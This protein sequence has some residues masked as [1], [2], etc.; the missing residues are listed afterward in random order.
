MSSRILSK[1]KNIP[2]TNSFDLWKLISNLQNLKCSYFLVYSQFV[3]V[4]CV[5]VHT[6]MCGML[7]IAVLA[8]IQRC[9]LTRRFNEFPKDQG[10]TV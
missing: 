1:D 5:H 7:S 3:S 10:H 8:Q 2:F 9:L 6:A 4:S